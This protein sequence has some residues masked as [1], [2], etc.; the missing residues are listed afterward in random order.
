MFVSGSPC[1]CPSSPD[2]S[3]LGGEAHPETAAGLEDSSGRA[4]PSG[5][6]FGEQGWLLLGCTN[7]GYR[8]VL[9]K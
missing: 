2:Q 7:N 5:E 6:K 9:G 4:L 8:V 3:F 1:V